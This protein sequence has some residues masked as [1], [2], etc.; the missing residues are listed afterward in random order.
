MTALVEA[1]LSN[2]IGHGKVPYQK[3]QLKSMVHA[4]HP[5]SAAYVYR[6]VLN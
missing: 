1:A 4:V 6:N 2:V 3:P 5:R